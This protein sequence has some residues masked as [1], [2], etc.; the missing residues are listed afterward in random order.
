[1][2]KN[3][4]SLA[5]GDNESPCLMN[6]SIIVPAHNEEHRLPMVLDAYARHFGTNFDD[7]FEIIV[8]ANNCNDATMRV[9]IE[10]A[11]RHPQIRVIEETR[12]IGKGGAVIRGVT[13]ARGAWVGFVDADGATAPEEMERLYRVALARGNGVIASRWMRGASVTKSQKGTRRL[14][15]RM[16]NLLVRLF[17]GLKYRDTQCGAK[18]FPVEAWRKI[19]PEIGVTRFAFDAAVL[20]QLQRH[21][22]RVDEEP[23]VWHDVEGS[24]VHLFRSLPDVF[25]AVVRMRLLYSPLRFVVD[26]YDRLLS[27][28]V[29]FLRAD[30]LFRHATLL[31]FAALIAH[32]CNILFQMIVGRVLPE[33]EYALLAAFLAVFAISARPLGTL[34]TAMNH[35]TSVM[36]QS[37]NEGLIGRLTIKWATLTVSASMVPAFIGVLFAD[38]IAAFFHLDRAAPVIIASLALPALCAA[39]VLNGVLSG[40]QRFAESAMAATVGAFLRVA[41]VG[42]LVTLAHSASGWAL[43][44]HVGGLYMSFGLMAV[45]LLPLVRGRSNCK[46][47][48]PSMRF[49]LAWCFLIQVG[50]GILMTADVVLVRRYFPAESDFA[51]AATLARLIL[52]LCAPVAVAMFP[53]VSSSGTF[54]R[55]HRGLYRRSILYTLAL[56]LLL[57]ILLA[58]IPGLMLRVFFRITTPDPRLLALTRQLAVIMGMTTLLQVNVNLLLAQR[59]FRLLS[60]I[61][62]CALL[63]VGAAYLWHPSVYAIIVAAGL[64]NAV[65][66]MATTFFIFRLGTD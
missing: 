39:P 62:A 17:L 18:I 1:M 37:G 61:V 40:M 20:F 55:E 54:T 56:V 24:T 12:K 53:K 9:A 21:G 4:Y 5:D 66:L 2:I 7:A 59:R 13:E 41:L 15:S 10:V 32:V 29:E 27:N 42:V 64:A 65:A 8:V 43:S 23:T 3:S 36:I 57:T 63:Y 48:I 46:G 34:D 14:A 11:G 38:R 58:V 44:A 51:Y 30:S 26:I 35:Y 45:F 19:L 60:V 16:F 6:L 25:L 33:S 52:F 22:F 31:S 28:A 49:Y 47:Q 50:A